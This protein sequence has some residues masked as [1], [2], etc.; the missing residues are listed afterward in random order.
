MKTVTVMTHRRPRETTEAVRDL[1][2][3]ARGQGWAVLA[4]SD[5]ADK[6]DLAAG[7]GLALDDTPDR[8]PDLCVA[9]GGDGTILTA[10]RRWAGRGV[11]VF[12]VNYGNIGFLSTIERTETHEGFTRALAGDFEILSLPAIA[13]ADS[14]IDY[15]AINDVSFQRQPGGRVA[16]LAY[17]VGGEEIGRVRCD[18]L[19]LATPAGSTGYNLANGGPL[20]AWGVEGYVVSFIAPHSLTARPLVV[21][22]NDEVTVHNASH[23]EAVDVSVDGRPACTL[24]PGEDLH[25]SFLPD[26]GLLAQ[27]PG[28]SFYHRL[29]QK[30]GALAL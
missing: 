19:V 27:L 23:D 26:Q 2:T 14:S 24:A 9:M 29:R 20:L 8:C 28:S 16:D 1:L 22:P 30:F 4:S 6:H 11:P 12:A 17:A 10:L 7:D 13:V 5:E 18:G 25:A 21:A 3:A 15:V